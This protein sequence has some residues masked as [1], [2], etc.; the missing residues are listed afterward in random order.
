[1]RISQLDMN[2]FGK[3]A[4]ASF[5][6]KGSITCFYGHNEA[7]KSTL[8]GFI[9]AILFG[10]PTR[11]NMK[12]RYEPL[13][14]G[15]H[16]GAVTLLD[17]Q[18]ISYRVERYGNKLRVILEDGTIAGD[19]LL[20]HLLKDMSSSTYKNLFA[21][22]LSELQE[23]S[24]LQSGE[25]NDYIFN[26]GIGGGA[27]H[28]LQ[29]EKR[30]IQEMEQLYK[31]RGRNQELLQLM[32]AM[33]ETKTELADARQAVSY[34][35]EYN[36]YLTQAELQIDELSDSLNDH[37]KHLSWLQQC[38]KT[39]EHW[40]K[41]N[42]LK[43][44]LQ[45]LP[46]F[47]LFP[48]DALRRYEK[49]EAEQENILIE[50][51]T[52]AHKLEELKRQ[53]IES[54][55]DQTNNLLE[56]RSR[57]DRQQQLE[58]QY[59]H[60]QERYEDLQ[61]SQEALHSTASSSIQMVWMSMLLLFNIALPIY[62]YFEQFTAAAVISFG[63]ILS[64]NAVLWLSFIQRRKLE[65]AS[66]KQF[67]MKLEEIR[68]RLEQEQE[69]LKWHHSIM[70]RMLASLVID[71]TAATSLESLAMSDIDQMIR[72]QQYSESKRRQLE[73]SLAQLEDDRART[74]I[75]KKRI[76]D[77]I[78]VLWAEAYAQDEAEFHR[79]CH[80]NMQAKDLN[81]EIRQVEMMIENW[82]H[83]DDWPKLG[84]LLQSHTMDQLKQEVDKLHT[85]SIE[86]N[87][88]M[89]ALREQRG[90]HQNLLEQLESGEEY[91][92]K[93]QHYEEQQTEY[94]RLFGQWATRA[95]CLELFKKAKELYE[96]DK[97]PEV[98]RRASDYFRMMTDHQFNRV[99]APLGEKRI[100]AEREN[101]EYVEAAYLSRGT[102]EQLYLA[103][104][105]A[106]ASEYREKK[107]SFPIVMD[108]VLVN[109]DAE[110][111]RNALKVIREVSKQQQLILFTCHAHIVTALEEIIPEHQMIHLHR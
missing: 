8:L 6:L 44:Q 100:M 57:K 77:K 42:A 12:E 75:S 65:R 59:H 68:S 70:T 66:S 15:I 108:D 37:A 39:R 85:S 32:K 49:L 36:E 9:R 52:I 61:H 16:G 79:H 95:L 90:K 25:L 99:T 69:E 4:D 105:L 30:L 33:E 55:E 101:G 98:M 73:Q 110:R 18:S 47:E 51:Q 84:T 104:R 53:P 58:V 22:G 27:S 54:Q 76:Q 21:F 64:I 45:A 60:S 46:Q 41:L 80:M 17:D 10:F 103:M 34:Y 67:A 35:N 106:L 24:T 28:I 2:G 62:L 14:G 40:L 43:E 74:E 7:G 86:L 91:A 19:Q 87:E 1:M 3:Y 97:Q 56:L 94:Q 93:L 38:M 102:A 48:D 20:Q 50:E 72:E 107:I 11:A 5:E 83:R 89:N 111:L 81:S 13:R 63:V 82:I 23:I 71:E 88:Q 96:K 31:P 26:A 109:F 78:A 92:R 29:A